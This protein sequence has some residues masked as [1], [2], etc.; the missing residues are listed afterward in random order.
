MKRGTFLILAISLILLAFAMFGVKILTG[1]ITGADFAGNPESEQLCMKTC[2]EVGCESGD[3]ECMT[4]NQAKCMT[5]CNAKPAP[6]DSGGQCVQDCIDQLC[7]QGPTYISC[8]ESKKESCDDECGMKGDAPDESNMDEEQLCISNCVA[9]IDPTLICGSSK[10]GET[11]NSICQKCA[12]QCVHLYKGPC[13]NDEQISEKE[14]ECETCE[15]CYGE[16][17]EGPSGQGWDCVIDIECNDATEEFGDV[18]GEGPG[19]IQAV[20]KGISNI[21]EG[22]GNFFSNLFGGDNS[23]ELEEPTE[24]IIEEEPSSEEEQSE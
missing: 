23:E 4:G 9:A 22:I 24:E 1:K 2:V 13:L 6:I 5:E 14:T 11:G 12:N 17:V 21:F 18:P 7:E 20:G 16:P 8:M 3:M 19:I 15:H 10:E